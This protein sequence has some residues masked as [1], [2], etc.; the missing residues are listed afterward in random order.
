MCLALLLIGQGALATESNDHASVSPDGKFIA[1][2]GGERGAKDIRILEIASGQV[3]TLLNIPS[4]DVLPTW[5]PDGLF[6]AFS[7]AFDGRTFVTV[8][9]MIGHS[10]P[11]AEIF[12]GHTTIAWSPDATHLIYGSKSEAGDWDLMMATAGGTGQRNLTES[13]GM[14]ER[15]PDWSKA[16]G[17]V[18]YQVSS[19]G[20]KTTRL[21]VMEPLK[22]KSRPLD[23]APEGMIAPRWSPDGKSLALVG[24]QR[25]K[26]DVYIFELASRELSRLTRHENADLAA[27]WFPD[28]RRL[29]FESLR[30]RGSF[31]AGFDLYVIDLETLEVDRL[32]RP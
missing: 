7:S 13:P 16:N 17:L 9:D 31:E 10:W 24:Y 23:G 21:R 14:D 8:S 15:W 32:T 2:D 3:R 19:A 27:S 5:S 26:P 30:D 22:R 4:D 11:V 18:I 25:Q 12:G 1:F 28:G 20:Q 29:A 6:I